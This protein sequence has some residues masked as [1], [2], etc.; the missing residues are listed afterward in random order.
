MDWFDKIW[1]TITAWTRGETRHRWVEKGFRTPA[2]I[3]YIVAENQDHYWL[4]LSRGD[5]LCVSEIITGILFGITTDDMTQYVSDSITS[6]S[7]NNEH[8]SFKKLLH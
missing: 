8:E 7:L 6:A 2:Y 3:H 5:R 1:Y 4:S